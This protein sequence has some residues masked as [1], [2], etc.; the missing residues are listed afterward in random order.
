MDALKK[1]QFEKPD[2]KLDQPND[3]ISV[4]QPESALDSKQQTADK[5]ASSN[6]SKLSKEDFIK[7]ELMK[8][9]SNHTGQAEFQTQL[10]T[11]DSANAKGTE[12]VLKS[13]MNSDPSIKEL[14]NQ[15]NYLVT[16]GGGEV[17]LKMN[18][19][20]GMGEVHLKVMLDNGK[21]N[22]ELNTQDKSVRKLIEDSLSDLRSSLAAK[23]ISLEHVRINSVNATNTENNS[24]SLQNSNQQSGS[25]SNH[26]KTFDQLQQQMQQ[27]KNQHQQR[28]FTKSLLNEDRPVVLPLKSVQKSAASQYYGLNKAQSLNAVA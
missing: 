28:N 17:T 20:D 12:A 5:D 25:E 8:T 18:S 4:V 16:Q 26:S 14:L 10:S 21:M 3:K 23:Q 27:Q 24:Q 7:S 19:A 22:I 2:L 13:E 15:A 6:D 1:E 11:R 9:E